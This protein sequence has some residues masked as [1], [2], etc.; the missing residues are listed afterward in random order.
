ML[1]LGK[2]AQR[3]EQEVGAH[4]AAEGESPQRRPVHNLVLSLLL[5]AMLGFRVR[6]PVLALAA[7]LRALSYLVLTAL[8]ALQKRSKGDGFAEGRDTAAGFASFVRPE[9]SR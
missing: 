5:S 3:S 7:C 8:A 2:L 4:A 6:A 1:E 9:P